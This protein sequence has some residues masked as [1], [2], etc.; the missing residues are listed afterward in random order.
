VV[1]VGVRVIACVERALNAV[2]VAGVGM[3]AL[4]HGWQIAD[5]TF[6]LFHSCHSKFF[7]G[8]RV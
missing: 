8:Y 6:G 7:A 5:K 2:V 4:A 1:V 3:I